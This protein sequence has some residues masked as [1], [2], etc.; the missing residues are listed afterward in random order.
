M[1]WTTDRW[2]PAPGDPVDTDLILGEV[3]D[4]LAERDALVPAGWVPGAF[5]RWDPLRGTPAGGGGAGPYATVA[6]FQFEIQE[7]LALD[8]PLRWWDLD[9]NQLYAFADLCQ[10]AFGRDGWSW[11]LTAVDGEGNPVNAWRPPYAALFEELYRAINRLDCLRLVPASSGT[12]RHDSVYRL[13]SG[14]SN[15]PQDRADTFALFDGQDDGQ[16]VGL[17]YDVGMGGEVLDDGAAQHWMLESRRFRITFATSA[18]AGYEVSRAWLHFATEAPQGSA[19]FS[20]TF[21][22]E[23]LD[24]QD[25]PLGSFASDAYGEKCLDVPAGSVNT[26]GETT[27]VVRSTRPDADDRSAWTATGPNHTSTYREGLAVA[28]PIRLI[29]EVRF[30][31]HQ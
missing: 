15:W 20:D 11:D 25:Q 1:P 12:E 30:D 2:P 14:I 19:D 21:T 17:A 27:F 18:L 9:R 29:V 26:E 31:Y 23:V 5:A 13:T 4:A 7:M 24:A 3:R 28:G 10:D 22:A 6:N 16:S 8:W